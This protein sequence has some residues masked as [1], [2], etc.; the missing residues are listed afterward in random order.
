[1]TNPG[2]LDS[3]KHTQPSVALTKI[4]R[5]SG[6]SCGG[7]PTGTQRVVGPLE[8]LAWGKIL[9]LCGY[10][11]KVIGV[12]LKAI[13]R[14]RYTGCRREWRAPMFGLVR[15]GEPGYDGTG[16]G[17]VTGRFRK[18]PTVKTSSLE[19]VF[20]GGRTASAEEEREMVKVACVER[21]ESD[22]V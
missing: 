6:M 21:L 18:R 19:D 7:G 5:T 1:M 8:L 10:A 9:T 17:A 13:Q 15:L 14:V 16:Q 4:I 12:V 22:I 2:K 11:L 3:K 20:A